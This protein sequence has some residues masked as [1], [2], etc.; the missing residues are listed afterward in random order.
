MWGLNSGQGSSTM[1][2]LL[3]T[4]LSQI[5]GFLCDSLVVSFT[6]LRQVRSICFHLELSYTA[7]KSTPSFITAGLTRLPTKTIT[8]PM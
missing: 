1:N 5:Y 7:P 6:D 2:F 3:I 8:G 4:W